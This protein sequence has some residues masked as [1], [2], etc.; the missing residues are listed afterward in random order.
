LVKA[1][2]KRQEFSIAAGGSNFSS[3]L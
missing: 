3:V 2:C 1:P